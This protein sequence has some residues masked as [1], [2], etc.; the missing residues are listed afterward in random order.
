[1][2]LIMMRHGES[3]NNVVHQISDEFGWQHR[4]D[5]PKL[6]PMGME[7]CEAVG[8]KMSEIGLKFDVILTSAHLRAL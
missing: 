2:R 1:M 8:K 6:S 5:D 7:E 3:Q 4:V